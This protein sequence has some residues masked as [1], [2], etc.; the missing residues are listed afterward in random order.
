[1]GGP[2]TIE[3]EGAILGVG[4]CCLIVQHLNLSVYGSTNEITA[5]FF[6]E[7]ALILLLARR[8]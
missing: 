4:A 7:N 3:H 6:K 8:K 2:F 1:M 5:P